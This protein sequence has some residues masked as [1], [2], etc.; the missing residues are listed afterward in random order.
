MEKGRQR[1]AVELS[2]A[3]ER[4]RRTL[5]MQPA[6]S[7]RSAPHAPKFQEFHLQVGRGRGCAVPFFS[8]RWPHQGGLKPHQPGASG[9]PLPNHAEVHTPQPLQSAARHAA[10][11]NKFAE[12]VAEERRREDELH[13]SPR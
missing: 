11:A 5:S 3:K 1:L 8:P 13:S 12:Q 9:A 2:A 6:R 4:C 7:V 10:Y